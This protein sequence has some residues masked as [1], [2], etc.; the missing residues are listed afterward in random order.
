MN[1]ENLKHFLLSIYEL[2]YEGLKQRNY[3][4]EKYILC[5]KERIDSGLYSPAEQMKSYL[6]DG[7]DLMYVADVFGMK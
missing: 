2:A 4:E 3:G 6:L 1:P 5:I 7:K